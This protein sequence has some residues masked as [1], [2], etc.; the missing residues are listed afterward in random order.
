MGFMFIYISFICS[1]VVSDVP[2]SQPCSDLSFRYEVSEGSGAGDGSIT[3]TFEAGVSSQIS[4]K[5]FKIDKAAELIQSK[6]GGEKARVEFENL[7]PADYLIY[8][9]WG[10]D[11]QRYLGG[12]EGIRVLGK[13]T[14]R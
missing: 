9:S 1:L 3:V 7:G 2:L 8:A 10:D 13:K 5:L 14:D 11:C 4:F 6:I 12:V